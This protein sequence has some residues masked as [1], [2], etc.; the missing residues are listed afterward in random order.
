MSFCRRQCNK[1]ALFERYIFDREEV[2]YRDME[3]GIRLTQ[4]TKAS[5]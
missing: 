4:M 5:G 2:Q 1:K 3:E